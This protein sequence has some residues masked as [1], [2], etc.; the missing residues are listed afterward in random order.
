MKNWLED[1]VPDDL[2]TKMKETTKK[3]S[4][5]NEYNAVISFFDDVSKTTIVELQEAINKLSPVGVNS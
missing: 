2:Y 3:Y 5:D 4:E 1:S